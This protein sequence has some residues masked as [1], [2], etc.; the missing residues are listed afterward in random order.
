MIILP[1]IFFAGNIKKYY[2]FYREL[3]LNRQRKRYAGLIP[4][5]QVG[6]EMTE[7]K[8]RSIFDYQR[9]ENNNRISTMLTDALGRYDFSGEGELSDDEAGLLNAA[10][11][12]VSAPATDGG[13]RV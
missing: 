8:L 3:H 5:E 11:T 7:Q 1:G 6:V 2:P 10:G 12:I 4:E 13:K 9:F